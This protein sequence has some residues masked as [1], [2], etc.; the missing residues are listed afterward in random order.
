MMFSSWYADS[1]FKYLCPENSGDTVQTLKLH[2][3]KQFTFEIRPVSKVRSPAL[4][5]CFT[6][7][8]MNSPGHTHTERLRTPT[9]FS[10]LGR[11]HE[12]KPC[13]GS[14]ILK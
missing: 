5:P 12:L 3:F 8:Q 2:Y 13:G 11:D 9:V 7:V 6:T 4:L 1:I 10:A 14:N